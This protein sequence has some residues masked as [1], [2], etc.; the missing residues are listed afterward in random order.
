VCAFFFV[1]GILPVS[2]CHDN[3][4]SPYYLFPSCII[5]TRMCKNQRPLGQV[6]GGGEVVAEEGG[7]V[8]ACEGGRVEVQEEGGD[9][10][11]KKKKKEKRNVPQFFGRKHRFLF[12]R[13]SCAVPVKGI[14]HLECDI[15]LRL[16]MYCVERLQTK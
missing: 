1:T 10:L 7:V 6:P 13:I 12:G 8:V 14:G 16:C 5:I 2:S 9:E 11:K 3:R 4:F 15:K